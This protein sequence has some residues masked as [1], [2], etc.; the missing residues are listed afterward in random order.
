MA[1]ARSRKAG[2]DNHVDRASANHM[3]SVSSPRI[4]V[5]ANG[6]LRNNSVNVPFSDQVV[7]SFRPAMLSIS[8]V[9]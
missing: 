8:V 2:G 3:R 5:A 6:S 9:R 4:G 1:K 7:P